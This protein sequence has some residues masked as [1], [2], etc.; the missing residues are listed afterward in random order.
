MT[1]TKPTYCPNASVSTLAE[2]FAFSAKERD[3]ETGLSYFGARYYSS[4]LSIWLSVDPMSGKYPST[5]PY[6]YCRNN[7]IILYD[8]NGMWDVRVS[9]STNRGKHPYATFRLFDRNGNEVF[10]TIVMVKGMHRRRDKTNG[11]TPTGVYKILGWRAT[12]GRYNKESYGENDLLALE[13]S[14]GSGE[15]NRYDSEDKRGGMH[16]HG[17]RK[18]E[19]RLVNT[20]GCIRIADDDIKELRSITDRLEKTDY[21]ES[22]GILTVSDDLETPIEY[23][24]KDQYRKSISSRRQFTV[25]EV[26]I[27]GKKQGQQQEQ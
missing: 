14:S 17:G 26:V 19:G 27:E 1:T 4:D 6:A 22:P 20:Q 18:R 12:G 16:V 24:D 25:K 21:R 11:D 7:P 15:G 13:Y 3:T 2:N 8:P 10:K 23:S 5:S 9:A